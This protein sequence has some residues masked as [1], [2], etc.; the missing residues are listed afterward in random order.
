MK[1]F[2]FKHICGG[3]EVFSENS[4]PSWMTSKDYKWFL[5]GFVLTLDVGKSVETDFHQRTRLT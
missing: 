2:E 5:D 4:M 1:T 3:E